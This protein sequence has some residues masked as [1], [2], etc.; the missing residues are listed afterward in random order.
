MKLLKKSLIALGTLAAVPLVQNI[1]KPGSIILSLGASFV[2]FVITFGIDIT[3]I[4]S[5]YVEKLKE[6]QRENME[7]ILEQRRIIYEEK[8]TYNKLGGD[9]YVDD[10][11]DRLKKE[12]KL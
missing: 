11:F 4:I 6:T 8:E 9:S 10:M 3:T 2:L 1:G 7:E 12:G 5:D